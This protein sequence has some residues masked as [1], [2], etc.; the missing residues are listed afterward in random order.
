[1]IKE[2]KIQVNIT[3]RNVKIFKEKGY[4]IELGK[5]Y[6][7]GVE[8]LPLGSHCE[9]TAICDIC[10]EEK[11]LKYVK[12]NENYKRY[13]FYSCKKCS[14]I[15]IKK[16]SFD[17]WG[18]SNYRKTQECNDKIRSTNLDK[19]GIENVFQVE[20]IKDKIRRTNLDRYGSEYALSSKLIR[21]KIKET[22]L[23]NWGVEHFSKTQQFYRLT[24]NNWKNQIIDKLKK[25]RIDDYILKDD[26]TIDMKC[27]N[28]F[29]H[30]FNI[31]SKNLYQRKEVQNTI[32]CTVCNK[33][34]K[35]I[36]GQEKKLKEFIESHINYDVL[37]NVINVMNY[38]LAKD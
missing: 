38:T 14:N 10:K 35:K 9:I 6:L 7:I 19:Y 36:S 22:T 25:Y 31:T 30:Y 17:K 33:I 32:I 15:K 13:N 3:N 8:D 11:V 1:M 2:E 23:K 24:Y 20:D 5:A 12:Y 28:G 37:S 34:D 29:N 4:D 21:N 27:D 26:R 16:T 18:V